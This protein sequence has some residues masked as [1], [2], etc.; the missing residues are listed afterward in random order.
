MKK[1]GCADF[2]NFSVPVSSACANQKAESMA[3]RWKSRKDLL[4]NVASSTTRLNLEI[5]A[6]LGM[7]TIEM[8]KSSS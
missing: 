5:A 2:P 6:K 4:M 7:Q 1:F 8:Q 3:S